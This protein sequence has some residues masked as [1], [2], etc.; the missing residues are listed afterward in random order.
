VG[1]LVLVYAVPGPFLQGNALFRYALVIFFLFEAASTV[2]WVN[3]TALFP[4]LFQ[5][6]RERARASST[7]QGLSMLGELTGF[8]VPPLMYALLFTLAVTFLM[9]IFG[10][11]SLATPFWVKYTLRASPQGTSLIF[12]TVFAAAILS[13]PA[14]GR[15]VRV[16]GVKRSWLWSVGLMAVMTIIFGLAPNLVVGAIGAAVGGAGMGGINVCRE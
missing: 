11:F 14:W 8:T 4:E 15:L 3:Y 9:F 1:I 12:A 6:F 2:M 7:Y 13:A 16:L 10:V 5:G